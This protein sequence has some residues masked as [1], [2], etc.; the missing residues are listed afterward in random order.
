MPRKPG[1]ERGQFLILAGIILVL[2]FLVASITIS[3]IEAQRAAA[4]REVRN[5]LL[6]EFEF[7]RAEFGKSLNVTFS[8]S[9]TPASFNVTFNDT[10]SVL[11][12]L[13]NGRGLEFHAA[14]AGFEQIAK[15]REC[16]H[17]TTD[18]DGGSGV[19]CGGTYNVNA[20]DGAGVFSW[21]YDG[22]NDGILQFTDGTIRGA[23]VYMFLSDSGSTIEEHLVYKLGSW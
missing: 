17:F 1:E 6:A 12:S 5:P 11:A 8:S 9:D 20:Y 21:T 13:E 2:A 18:A 16:P 10:R 23:V 4:V 19:S 15:Q 14:L 7:V 22:K 3:E